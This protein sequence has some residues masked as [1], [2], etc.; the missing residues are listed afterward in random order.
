MLAR[1]DSIH[2]LSSRGKSTYHSTACQVP[3]ASRDP[4]AAMEENRVWP[5]DFLVAGRGSRHRSPRREKRHIHSLSNTDISRQD[6]GLGNYRIF[7]AVLILVEIVRQVSQRSHC[8]QRYV[9]ILSLT[10]KL[11]SCVDSQGQTVVGGQGQEV[12]QDQLQGLES[13]PDHRLRVLGS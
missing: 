10:A 9:Q 13:C 4:W 12:S 5:A 6:L 2:T 11:S 8:S 7:E 1:P 3:T